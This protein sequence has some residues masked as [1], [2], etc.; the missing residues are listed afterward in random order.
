MKI[1]KANQYLPGFRPKFSLTDGINEIYEG[2]KKFGLKENHLK[3]NEFIILNRYKKLLAEEKIS[4]DFR[5]IAEANVIP[6]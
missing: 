5:S 3:S 6:R 1:T 4:E 2:Y